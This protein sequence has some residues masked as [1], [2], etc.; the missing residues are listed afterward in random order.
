MSR[1]RRR[2]CRCAL[3][4]DVLIVQKSSAVAI[5]DLGLLAGE[6]RR[7]YEFSDADFRV[8]ARIAKERTGITLSDSKRNLLYGR[9]SRRLRALKM[10]AFS[11]Y[12]EYLDGPHGEAELERFINSIS[13]NHTKLFREP[14]HFE[15]LR[16]HIAIPYAQA[17]KNHKA[18]R[19][20]IWSAGCSSGEEPYSIAM[21]LKREIPDCARRDIRILASD[22]DTDVIAK[23]ARGEYPLRMLDEIPEPYRKFVQFKD[24]ASDFMLMHEDL[25]A[26][27]AFRRLNLIDHPWP[28]KGPFD[29]IFCR[30]VMIY[31][32]AQTKAKLIE[33]YTQM[34]KLGGWLYIGHS[35]SLLGVHPGLELIGR[36]VYRRV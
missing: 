6:P 16:A 26:I 22:I 13:T 36:T 20:R 15:H 10:S 2:A 4:G 25:R 27:I 35:E 29:A 1:R 28:F 11:E 5:Q 32:D 24:K 3:W 14:H 19:L 7:E 18:G 33:R 30:N 9:L 17:I 8:L 12:R 21:V 31:F 34:L 23:G